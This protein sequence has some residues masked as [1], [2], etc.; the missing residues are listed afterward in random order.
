MNKSTFD[1]L[2]QA[3]DESPK[4]TYRWLVLADYLEEQGDK[5]ADGLRWLV[6]NGKY[7][8]PSGSTTENDLFDV[9]WWWVGGFFE[10][11][12]PY[13]Q[14]MEMPKHWFPWEGFK[15]EFDFHAY[16]NSLSEAI[17]VAAEKFSTIGVIA[18]ESTLVNHK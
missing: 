17:L 14:A 10:L 11:P 9:S 8:R 13:T 12:P 15:K 2:C 4:E 5:R 3:I 16:F 7:P 1:S 6:E 18:N